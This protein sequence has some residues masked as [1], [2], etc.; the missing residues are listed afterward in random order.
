MTRQRGDLPV[1]LIT[2]R[3]DQEFAEVLDVIVHTTHCDTPLPF[4]YKQY[5]AHL[6]PEQARYGY[7]RN[8]AFLNGS[9]GIGRSGTVAQTPSDRN[10]CIDYNGHSRRP[11]SRH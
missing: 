3:F 8:A 5:M 9:I 2:I 7:A 1:D 6:V 10:G 4:P 11:W